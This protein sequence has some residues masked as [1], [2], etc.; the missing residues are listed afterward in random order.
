[1]CCCDA[2]SLFVRGGTVQARQKAI[3]DALANGKACR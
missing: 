2:D 1:L 3:A